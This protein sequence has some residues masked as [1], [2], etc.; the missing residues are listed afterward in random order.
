MPQLE[1]L[2]EQFPPISTK[3]WMDKITSDLKGADFS[4]KLVW[5]TDEGFEVKPFYRREDIEHIE[6]IDKFLSLLL[7]GD[8]PVHDKR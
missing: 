1:K 8:V 2:F 7:R 6:H 4:K 3:E 5:K